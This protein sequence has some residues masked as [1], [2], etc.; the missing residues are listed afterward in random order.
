[1]LSPLSFQPNQ[2]RAN[3]GKDSSDTNCR[4]SPVWPEIINERT[5]Y[6]RTGFTKYSLGTIKI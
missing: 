3:S 6:T 5:R 2:L 1:M 4:K